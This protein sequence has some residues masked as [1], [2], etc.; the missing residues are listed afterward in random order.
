MYGEKSLGRLIG[1]MMLL[2]MAASMTGFFVVLPPAFADPGY[3]VN[4]AVHADRVRGGALL[5]LVP[6]ALMLGI[7]LAGWPLF[8]RHGERAALGLLAL[9]A[10]LLAV[11]VVEQGLLLGML[12]LSQAF[13]GAGPTQRG[14]FEAARVV[15]GGARYWIHYL[16]LFS[17]GVASLT[18]YALLFRSRLLPRVLPAFGVAAVALHLAAIMLHVGGQPFDLTLVAPAGIGQ[19]VTGCWLAALGFHPQAAA[20]VA[21][22][23]VA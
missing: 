13:D 3:L 9:A 14:A 19:L 17:S 20:P 21:G 5:V 22:A 6:A 16:A 10:V 12:S 1:L 7:A 11:T 15:A 18:L 8:R 2:A 23:G 4:A